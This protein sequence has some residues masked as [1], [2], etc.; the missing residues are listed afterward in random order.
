MYYAHNIYNTYNIAPSIKMLLEKDISKICEDYLKSIAWTFEYYFKGCPE[1][2]WYYPH[3][4]A[5]LMIDFH[6]YLTKNN[7]EI[8]FNNDEPYSP[9]QQ[10]K[11]VLPK[12][13][14]NFM[15][16]ED[17]PVYSFFKTY[18]WECHAI[19]PHL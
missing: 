19:L 13:E 14:K 6:E 5:P 2:R 12:L 9:E 16:P 3:D 1:W 17:T 10:L 4:L 11:I 7:G 18:M 8:T 15:Y